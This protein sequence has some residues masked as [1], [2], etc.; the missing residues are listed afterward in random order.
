M[1]LMEEHLGDTEDMEVLEDMGRDI[2]KK[3]TLLNTAERRVFNRTTLLAASAVKCSFLINMIVETVDISSICITDVILKSL[4]ESNLFA[5]LEKILTETVTASRGIVKRR[6]RYRNVYNPEKVIYDYID[7]NEGMYIDEND[8]LAMLNA[9]Y[10]KNEDQED[11]P[12]DF[13]IIELDVI[14]E[15]INQG[16][17]SSDIINFIERVKDRDR[18]DSLFIVFVLKRKFRL[19]NYLFTKAHAFKFDYP[20][21]IMCLENDAHDIAVLLFQNFDKYFFEPKI[22]DNI[23]PHLVNSFSKGTGLIEAK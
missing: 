8:N 4:V 1:A 5:T 23:V 6:K 2:F 3:L 22:R 12:S 20:L 13:S 15:M 19:I 16:K 17:E 11:I 18:L 9:N 14:D 10:L 7:N 21:F